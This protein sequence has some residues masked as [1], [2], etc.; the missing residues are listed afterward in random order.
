MI[1]L[2]KINLGFTTETCTDQRRGF[3]VGLCDKGYLRH[4]ITEQWVHLNK[5]QKSS[6]CEQRIPCAFGNYGH[7]AKHESQG[8]L[9]G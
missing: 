8:E 3:S 6:V 4:G 1:A 2:P 9:L 7:G 5:R